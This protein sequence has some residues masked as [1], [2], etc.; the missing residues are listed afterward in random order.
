MTD[1]ITD[2]VFGESEPETPIFVDI[3]ES[4]PDSPF[5]EDKKPPPDRHAGPRSS[6]EDFIGAGVA[7]AGTLLVSKRIDVPVGRCVQFQAAITG[8]KIDELIANTWV[9]KLL[10]PLFRKGD[11]FNELGAVLGLPILI[12]ICERKPEMAPML[13]G[14]MEE[15]V[16]TTLNEMAAM[17]KKTKLST[18][19]AVRTSE[20]RDMLE[21][22][23]DVKDEQIPTFVVH[24]FFATEGMAPD[25]E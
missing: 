22:P 5:Q 11:Q 13:M 25:G 15:F 24:S 10:Q 18:R 12:G 2:Q 6:G 16:L 19:R 21:V 9:D 3:D 7:F 8:K 4:A 23:D 1:T 14:P 20:I 17:R